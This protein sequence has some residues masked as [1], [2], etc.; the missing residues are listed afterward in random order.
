MSTL[1]VKP[2]DTFKTYKELEK[3]LELRSKNKFEKWIKKSAHPMDWTNPRRPVMVYK[4]ITIRC[5]HY[6][7]F[8]SRGTKR[9]NTTSVKIGCEAVIKICYNKKRDVL[10]VKD[11]CLD[12]NH[13]LVSSEE[14]FYPED[15]RLNTE[16]EERAVALGILDTDNLTNLTWR[17]SQEFGKPIKLKDV[18]NLKAKLKR[19][20]N[21]TFTKRSR[22]DKLTR[23]ETEKVL[24]AALEND[25]LNLT[26]LS[27]KLTL[28]FGKPVDLHYLKSKYKN[29]ASL[30]LPENGSKQHWAVHALDCLKQEDSRGELDKKLKVST[31][32]KGKCEQL[33][34]GPSENIEDSL[35]MTFREAEETDSAKVG[36]QEEDYSDESFVNSEQ[37]KDQDGCVHGQVPEKRPIADDALIEQAKKR[38]VEVLL[39]DIDDEE[40]SP[41]KRHDPGKI[42][43]RSVKLLTKS[44]G[45]KKTKYAG[46]S[47]QDVFNCFTETVE[48]NTGVA[49]EHK[50]EL[51]TQTEEV[52]PAPP[53]L[54]VPAAF[55]RFVKSGLD[56]MK[57]EFLPTALEEIQNILL[58]YMLKE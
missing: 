49:S 35:E 11:V 38:R 52:G 48:S 21:S 29:R 23:E 22:R 24:N 57:Q 45:R 33:E 42:N 13:P 28:E 30:P 1:D 40:T 39:H 46:R 31:S 19:K 25:C 17:L 44:T 41:H 7:T 37:T 18:Y 51:G 47:Y 3:F 34:D 54:A 6:G 14:G 36:V 50:I 4:H 8:K 12:H 16:E 58:A 43:P 9:R 10:L 56:Q 32:P 5:K 26:L 15:R 55:A 27:E 2:G 53:P 20:S